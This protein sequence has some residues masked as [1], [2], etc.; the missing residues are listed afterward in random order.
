M[1]IRMP[2]APHDEGAHD[3]EGFLYVAPGIIPHLAVCEP[4]RKFLVGRLA[5]FATKI[6]GIGVGGIT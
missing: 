1:V 2:F 5:E 3:P 6:D 4:C